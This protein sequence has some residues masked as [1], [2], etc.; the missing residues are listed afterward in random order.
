MIPYELVAQALKLARDNAV[1][2]VEIEAR[3][4]RSDSALNELASELEGI[5]TAIRAVGQA[6]G[7]Q[8]TG[9]D[10]ERFA[11]LCGMP[12]ENL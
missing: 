4:G 6:L 2:N 8:V 7:R 5:N 12:R 9:L 3:T 11:E 10:Y 1:R